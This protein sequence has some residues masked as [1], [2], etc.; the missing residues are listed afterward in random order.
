MLLDKIDN[1]NIKNPD[2]FI[3]IFLF[4]K[5]LRNRFRVLIKR[6]TFARNLY[7]EIRCQQF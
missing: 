1:Y 2:N 5:T 3:R 6:N 7:L 4:T